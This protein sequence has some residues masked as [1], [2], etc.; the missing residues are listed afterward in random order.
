MIKCASEKWK[1]IFI[2]ND[3]SF[4]VITES[5]KSGRDIP[6]VIAK[7]VLKYPEQVREFMENGYWWVNGGVEGS[8]RPGKSFDFGY[9]VDK[10]FIP[11]VDELVELYDAEDVIPI[12]FYGNCYNGN[13]DL[14][15]TM[16]YLPHVDTFPGDD[17]NENPLNDFAFNLNLTKSDKVKTAFYSFNSKRSVCDFTLD[18]FEDFE[19]VKDKHNEMKV[20][21][22]RK[23]SD[24]NYEN[25]KLEYIADIEYNSM[26]LYP[27]HYW[28]NCYLKEEWFTDTDRIT[29]TGFFETIFSDDRIGPTYDPEL[30]RYVKKL[31]FD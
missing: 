31:G 26:I 11:L 1:E 17:Q 19:R 4:E 10:Y 23:L 29:F 20:K 6:I 21:Q 3:L 7:D 27:S 5:C 28:H 30:T 25:Y 15:T 14:Y 9:D 2:L 24:N 12:E 22:W 18:D 16:S 13:M 8:L